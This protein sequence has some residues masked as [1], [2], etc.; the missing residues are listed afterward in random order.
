MAMLVSATTRLSMTRGRL[1][2]SMRNGLKMEMPIMAAIDRPTAPGTAMRRMCTRRLWRAATANRASRLAC[3]ATRFWAEFTA[4][5]NGLTSEP[6]SY[7]GRPDYAACDTPDECVR[8][9]AICP[10]A[11]VNLD[12]QQPG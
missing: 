9:G 11:R 5:P 6:S 3:W 1:G 2:I 7:R 8:N 10:T 12:E 4:A